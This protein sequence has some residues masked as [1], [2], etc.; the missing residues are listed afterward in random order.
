EYQFFDARVIRGLQKE[1]ACPPAW[2]GDV[3]CDQDTGRFRGLVEAR[4]GPLKL[5]CPRGHDGRPPESDYA[6]GADVSTGS[7]ATNSC[8]S[9]VECKTGE[10]VAE[11]AT[12]YLRPE[13]FAAKAVALCR[14]FR[15]V[16]EEGAAFCWEMQGPGVVF[17][18][19][20]IASGYRRVYYR[21]S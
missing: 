18:Q 11:Y 19:K 8:L 15:P 5:W 17:G 10:K 21:T 13:A 6:A 1:T 3:D 12:P 16:G 20:V 4:G 7:G 2:E 14:Y 9:V